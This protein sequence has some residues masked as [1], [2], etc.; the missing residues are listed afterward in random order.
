MSKTIESMLNESIISTSDGDDLRGLHEN[1]KLFKHE[2]IKE[3]NHQSNVFQSTIED[4]M[5]KNKKIIDTE[6]NESN[7]KKPRSMEKVFEQRE[8]LLTDLFKISHI[9][10]L[11]HIFI[12]VLMI[13]CFQII[14]YDL[15]NHGRVNLDFKLFYWLFDGFMTTMIFIWLPMKL[16]VTLIVYGL[17]RLYASKR[18]ST[19]YNPKIFD[20]IFLLIQ[21][22]FIVMLTGI[23]LFW[24]GSLSLACRFIILMEQVRLVMKTHAFIRTN[25]PR[26]LAAAACEKSDSSMP[27]P[28]PCPEFSKYLY[29]LFAPTLVY[30][31]NYP[32][33]IGPI[34]WKRVIYH[35]CEVA[36]CMVYT[37]CL[38][39]RYCVPVFR[40]LNVQ[41][42]NLVSYIQLVSIS[43]L[44]G[45][46]MQMM[47]F[48]SFLHSWHNAWAEV[49]K[50]GDRQFYLDWWNS[51]SFNMYYRTWNT[52][53]H[54]WLYTYIYRDLSY[55][56]GKQYK[57]IAQFGVI[58]I[59][60][61]VH[62]YILSFAFGFF[63]PVMMVMFSGFG[64]VVLFLPVGNKFSAPWNIFVWTA[65]FTG[66][67]IQICFFGVE[68]YAR[69]TSGC[70]R[71]IDGIVDYL[72]PR[73][74]LCSAF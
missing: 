28:I 41:K 51:T 27:K 43:I 58:F 55:L 39:D 5:T 57:M 17:F 23:P 46:M 30:R 31:D 29:F 42:M 4:L 59:S 14:I 40:S 33:T 62:E 13:L 2:I 69:E 45:A 71:N 24:I 61:L 15:T 67:G 70:P 52:L 19:K 9:R 22:T 37:Y 18:N 16:S 44:P 68:W 35:L 49:L 73:S 20:G 25:I 56:L 50:F 38:F 8:S 11:R 47:V 3:I 7:K 54:D 72:V 63:L 12:S 74:I 32:R 10:T 48:F 21:V 1:V 36:G 65:L 6:N 60:G 64:F 53:V 66:L 26:V 34:K